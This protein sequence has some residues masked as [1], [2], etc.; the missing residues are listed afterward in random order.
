MAIR[1]EAVAAAPVNAGR[2]IEDGWPPA[3]G[4]AGQPTADD[5]G[6]DAGA[7]E[8][9]ASPV[10]DSSGPRLNPVVDDGESIASPEIVT[11][12]TY[13]PLPSR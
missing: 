3:G 2:T 4:A 8:W 5:G 9:G 12:L 11:D 13:F 7:G 10:C 1:H 6:T